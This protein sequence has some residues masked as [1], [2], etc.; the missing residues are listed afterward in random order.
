MD[1]WMDGRTDGW[2]DGWM[3]GCVDGWVCGWMGGMGWDGMGWNGMEWNG[4]D[5]WMG[6]WMDG[7]DGM[8]WD[9]MEWNGMD[10]WMDRWMEGLRTI[11]SLIS[12]WSAILA[13]AGTHAFAASLLSLLADGLANG[14]GFCHPLGSS[15]P[16][17]LLPPPPPVD[18]QGGEEDFGFCLW[19]SWIVHIWRLAS[20]KFLAKPV[21]GWVGGLGGVDGVGGWVDGWMGGKTDW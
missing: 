8:G 21:D 13:H 7:W 3:D 1:G 17:P 11:T 14:K 10:G 20:I 15:S 5:G 6:V 4:M 2:M 16:D 9:G 12:R 18:F 19:V